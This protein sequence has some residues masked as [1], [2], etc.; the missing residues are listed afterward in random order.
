V[1]A[2][3]FDYASALGSWPLAAS[4]DPHC[5]LP[6]SLDY[7]R[8]NYSAVAASIA[9]GGR[10]LC[11]LSW[12]GNLYTSGTE[13]R[14]AVINDPRTTPPGSASPWPPEKEGG[15]ALFSLQIY[16]MI[17]FATVIIKGL[18]S[19]HSLLE[20]PFGV[21]P[22]K[23]PLRA[24]NIDHIRQTR[25]MLREPREREPASVRTIFSAAAEAEGGAKQQETREPP[26]PPQQPG[27]SLRDDGKAK[28]IHFVQRDS[29]QMHTDVVAATTHASI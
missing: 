19:M 16:A 4:P 1:A 29:S 10:S 7:N 6:V 11:N 27:A 8:V 9:L 12:A 13:N 24:Y 15:G 22:C 28:G 5:R 18:L 14:S 3:G 20:N 21:H 2:A 25:A 17:A 23:F 26:P